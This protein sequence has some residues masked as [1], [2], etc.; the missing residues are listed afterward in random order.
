MS[1]EVREAITTHAAT[2]AQAAAFRPTAIEPRRVLDLRLDGVTP[3]TDDKGAWK[4]WAFVAKPAL[5]M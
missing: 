1:Q 3:L 2:D 5:A 4:R